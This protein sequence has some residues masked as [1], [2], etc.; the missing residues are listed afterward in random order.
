MDGQLI[1][2]FDLRIISGWVSTHLK[3]SLA[4]EKIYGIS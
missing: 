4:K 1:G 3:L 2:K